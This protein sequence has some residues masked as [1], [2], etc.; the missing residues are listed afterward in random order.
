MADEWNTLA[1]DWS[2]LDPDINCYYAINFSINI[3]IVLWL[4]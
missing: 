4:E 1:Q 2:V 3:F